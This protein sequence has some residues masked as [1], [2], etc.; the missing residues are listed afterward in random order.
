MDELIMMAHGSGGK[1]MHELIRNLFVKY[2]RNP[3]LESGGDAAVVPPE[4]GHIAFTTDSYVVDPLFFPGGD[5]GKLAVSGTINDLAVSGA[6]PRYI[7]AGFIIEEGFPVKDL[8]SVVRSM[9]GTAKQAGVQIVAGDTKVV[10]KGKCDRLFV[11][12]S[13]VGIISEK[14]THIATADH[15]KAG[16]Q[17]IISGYVGD[18]GMAVLSQRE[19]FPVK[20]GLKS[21][22]TPLNDLIGKVLERF[23]H[24]HFMR[25]PTRGGVA[26]AL[27]E[28]AEGRQ[29]GVLIKE[30]A[31]PVREEVM[32][33]SEM[34][35]FDPLYVPCEGRVLI[36]ADQS[37]SQGILHTLHGHPD[38][39]NAA[40]I[41]EITT[42][43][44]GKVVLETIAGGRRII[45]MLTGEQL[46]RIC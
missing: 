40:V 14:H 28:L 7:S 31:I 3:F 18:H 26:T 8:E 5:I 39:E 44:W 45:H 21:D 43:N 22:C 15:V 36:V 17:V 4:P 32:G 35:G 6:A 29:F 16:D 46:P 20:T 41:G 24:V 13:G 27:C 25:D 30:P 34:F 19:G 12:T 33:L 11:N 38:G 10:N 2:F 1:K 37:V 42:G 23:D 9:A